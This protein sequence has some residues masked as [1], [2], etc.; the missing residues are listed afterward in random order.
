MARP[1]PPELGAFPYRRTIPTRWMDNDLYGHVNNVHYYSFF[2]T[3]IAL[4]LMEEGGLDPWRSEVVGMAIE[5]LCRFHA[6]IAFPEPVTA[7]LRVGH[8]GRTSVRYEIGIFKGDATAAAADGHFVH[9]F[10][11]RASQR[12]HP[13]PERIRAA[14]SRILADRG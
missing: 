7:G 4:F 1:T 3:V 9:V 5:S 12:P 10:V 2:D 14:L 11:D 6:S 8:L 13:I